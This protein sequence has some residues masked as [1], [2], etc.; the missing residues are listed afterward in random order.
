[1]FLPILVLSHVCF[2]LWNSGCG[3]YIVELLSTLRFQIQAV[4]SD[5]QL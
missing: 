2:V 4:A 1:M 5:R 3:L